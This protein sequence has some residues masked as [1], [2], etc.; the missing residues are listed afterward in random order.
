MSGNC[1]VGRVRHGDEPNDNHEDRN[2]H[3]DD[4]P[5][6][7]EFRHPI[8][9]RSPNRSHLGLT[10]TPS[11]TFSTPSVITPI[12]GIEPLV[13]DPHRTHSVPNLHVADADL[14]VAAHNRDLVGSLEFG[15]GALR[16]EQGI[17]CSV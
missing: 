13:D 6:D 2:H 12:S 15:D 8:G 3:R 10:V 17:F 9:L 7:K 16:N 14:V 4:G 1:A 11:R 5:I